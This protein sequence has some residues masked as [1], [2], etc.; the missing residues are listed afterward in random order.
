MA[1]IMIALMCVIACIVYSPW[2]GLTGLTLGIVIALLALFDDYHTYHT[3]VQDHQLESDPKRKMT[4]RGEHGKIVK[5]LEN[6]FH[7]SKN[8]LAEHL[9][10]KSLHLLGILCAP[11]A[12]LWVAGVLIRDGKLDAAEA[13]LCIFY[14]CYSMFEAQKC[15][16]H[17]VSL[18]AAATSPAAARPRQQPPNHQS[19][20]PSLTVEHQPQPQLQSQTH[21][22]ER[23]ESVRGLI[24]F[25][26]THGLFEGEP[27]SYFSS[28]NMREGSEI[29]SKDQTALMRTKSRKR[30]SVARKNE[31]KGATTSAP[32]H[33]TPHHTTHTHAP[34]RYQPTT[35]PP[36]AA[37]ANTPPRR[38]GTA[39]APL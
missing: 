36:A 13:V 11:V 12:F 1:A 14:F 23:A 18:G 3:I 38:R 20:T 9:I 10:T 29:D 22:M 6:K 39:P 4:T 19:P 21:I 7:H 15:H 34:C 17:V 2:L 35:I 26:T 24:E 32:H 16:V 33:T 27:G 25:A 30:M 28:I 5:M 31:E 8:K 37:H